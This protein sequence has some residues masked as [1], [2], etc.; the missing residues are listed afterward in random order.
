MKKRKLAMELEKLE[1]PQVRSAALEQYPTPPEIAADL[2]FFAYSMEDIRD[3]TVC[4]LGCG[5]GVFGIGAALLGAGE[6]YGIDISG[7]MVEM[8]RKN[9]EKMGVDAEFM[10]GDV[11]SFNKHCDTVIQNPPF[12]AQNRHADL[13]FMEKAAEVGDVAY[14]MHMKRTREFVLRTF[15][16]L[17][18]RITHEMEYEFPIKRSFDFHRKDVEFINIIAIRYEKVIE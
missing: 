1:V 10:A 16:G 5:S 11:K 2:L 13:P 18:G 14:S 8:A 17:G 7:H 15:E 4:D 3:R 6:V 9:A 12:G